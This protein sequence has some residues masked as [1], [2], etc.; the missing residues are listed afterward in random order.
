MYMVL[1][2]QRTFI[3]LHFSDFKNILF[4]EIL[5]GKSIYM[6]LLLKTKNNPVFIIIMIHF[7]RSTFLNAIII[8]DF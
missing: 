4:I 3:H 5:I 8:I 1:K 7:H 6:F 2:S